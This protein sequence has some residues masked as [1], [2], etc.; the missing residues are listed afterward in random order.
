[1]AVLGVVKHSGMSRTP[2]SVDA[3]GSS[4]RQKAPDLLDLLSSGEP[5]AFANDQN[6]RIIFWNKGAERLM[7]RTAAQALG[8]LCHEIFCGK[9]PF[10][11]RFCGETCA[12]TTSLKRKEP[13]NRFE[14]SSGDRT[15]SKSIGMTVVEIPDSRPGYF[16]A[17]HI[18]ESIDE[19]GRLARE[20]ARLRE[21]NGAVT[22]LADGSVPIPL[23]LP[24]AAS[25]QTIEVDSM[26]TE[27]LSDRE[28]D[29]LR[30]IASGQANKDIANSLHISVATTRNHVQHILKK[31]SVH[32]K[33][34]AVALAFR[35][36]WA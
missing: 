21:M 26:V 12:V 1:M 14:I 31:L 4:P 20:L 29:V 8:R 33:L 6:H 3:K 15:R 5:P 27:Q 19:K 28:L 23:Q 25:T 17:V 35:N 18:M 34:E 9:D 22:H 13:V 10:G 32:S 16:T 2:P 7:E 24:H 30:A 36:G 11:N